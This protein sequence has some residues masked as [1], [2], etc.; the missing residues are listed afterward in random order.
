LGSELE[1]RDVLPPE[2]CLRLALALTLALDH[3]HRQK[4][5]HRD[6]KPANIIY[7]NHQPKFADIGL[8][9]SS[10]PSAGGW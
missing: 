7:V 2:E 6:I 8:V 9:T 5:I 10:R 3:L 4:L 1:D